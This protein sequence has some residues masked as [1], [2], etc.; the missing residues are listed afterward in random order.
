MYIIYGP[1]DEIESHPSGGTYE[2]PMDEAGVDFHI[3]FEDWRYR[4]IEGSDKK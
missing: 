2:R 3:S 1:A 4:Y